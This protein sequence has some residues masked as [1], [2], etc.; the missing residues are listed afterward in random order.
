[1]APF[2]SWPSPID[3]KRAAISH[4][5]LSWP[6]YVG[7]H[8]VWWAEPRPDLE[9]RIILMRS[10]DDSKGYGDPQEV[11]PHGKWNVRSRVIEYGGRAWMAIPGSG[12][13]P[14]RVVFSHYDDQ[15]LY[16][17]SPGDSSPKPLTPQSPAP[18]SLRYLLPV[19]SSDGKSVWCLHEHLKDE[20]KPTEVT[21]SFV[22][23]PLDGTAANNSSKVTVLFSDPDNQHFLSGPILSPDKLRVA[24]FSWNH[25]D[26]PWDQTELQVA[27][28][29]GT[30]FSKPV[31]PASVMLGSS[32]VQ[33]EWIDKDTLLAVSDYLENAKGDQGRWWKLYEIRYQNGDWGE[34]T[35]LPGQPDEE[36]GGYLWGLGSRWCAPMP[37]NKIVVLHGKGAQQL[38]ILDLG[39]KKLTPLAGE[40]TDWAGYLDVRGNYV[41][42]VASRPVEADAVIEV[43]LDGHGKPRVISKGTSYADIE[44]YLP[45]PMTNP[46]SFI[47]RKG[48]EIYATVYQPHNPLYT[49]QAKELPPYVMY[50]HGGPTA[51]STLSLDLTVAYFTSR[52][53]GVAQVNYGGSTGYGREY[54]NRLRGQWGLL[55]VQDTEDIALALVKENLADRQRLGIRGGSAG[56]FTSAAAITSDES[57]DKTFAAATVMYP[58]LDLVKFAMGGTHDFES[59][60]VENLL[61][62]FDKEK[63]QGRS[64]INHTHNISVPFVIIQGLE[65]PICPPH[66]CYTF[67]T[68]LVTE[69]GDE[70][71]SHSYIGFHGEAHGFR[72]QKNIVIALEAE[73]SLYGTAFGFT[74]LKDAH[75]SP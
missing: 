65:D 61:G 38:G 63:Y 15:R 69:R 23:V 39:A 8:E 73:L 20:A 29:K 24:W 17:Y 66:Q 10:R 70:P 67:L 1:M 34:P 64:P 26:M 72:K 48:K 21:R 6:T 22:S 2:G 31:N 75:P 60:Y 47:N 12:N 3:A 19:L 53:I 11:L 28:V 14:P 59:H 9:G 30:S 42:G 32:V 45:T 71:P 5:T 50:V 36:F 27:E 74:P 57:T 40:Y 51:R 41:L 16:S 46:P 68:N 52:G 54:R 35:L 55:D 49:G 43:D 58:V 13:S 25:P 56:G 4:D 18:E 44:Q 37:T 7:D 62:K 33:V